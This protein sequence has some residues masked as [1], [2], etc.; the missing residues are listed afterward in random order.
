MPQK[1]ALA[2]NPNSGKTTLFNQLTGSTAHVGN[3]P[4]V[5]VERKEGTYKKAG[6]DLQIIDLPG[7]YSLSPYSPEEVVARNYILTDHPDAIINI[8]DGTNLERNLYLTTQIL[9][10]G[11]PVVIALNM[12][13]AVNKLG[14]KID[15]SALESKLGVPVVPISANRNDG[16]EALMKRVASLKS[17]KET[18]KSVLQDTNLG[19]SIDKARE[20]LEQAGVSNPLFFAVKAIENDDDALSLL[21]LSPSVT[22]ELKEARKAAQEVCEDG[23]VEATTADLRYKFITS[24]CAKIIKKAPR[25]GLMSTS[26]KIDRVITNKYLGIPIF[27]LI[28]FLVFHLTFTENLFFVTELPGPGIWLAGWVETGVEVGTEAINGALESMGA[29]DW[30]IGLVVDGILAGVGAVLGFLPLVMVLYLFLSLLESSGYMAR[31]AFIMDRVL[32][33]F[34]LSGKAFVPMLMGFGCSVPAISATRTLESD[35]DRKMTIMLI[36]FMSCGAKLPIYALIAPAV[37]PN[38]SDVAVFSMY[39]LGII[40]AIIA[41]IILKKKVFGGDVA[42][43]IMEL[44]AYRLPTLKSIG[45]HLWEKFKGFATKVGTIITVATIIIWFL[46]NFGFDGGF[47]MVEPNSAQSILG[48]VGNALRFIFIPLGF[49]SGPEGWKMVVAVIT[50]LV[51][52]EAVVSTMGQL[53]IPGSEDVMESDTAANN[54]TALLA[55]TMSIPAA[56][57]FMAW[58]LLSIPCMAAVGAISDEM[59]SRKWMWITLGF[60]MITAWI[61]SFVLYWASTGIIALFGL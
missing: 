59:K 38:R 10:T 20:S 48:Y 34:G 29:S 40:V 49:A 42:P 35:R 26:D 5:T 43:F 17:K 36:P 33:R 13:D 41:G 51:A 32:R 2:G 19:S 45:V 16:I 14:D 8:V 30:A 50:G 23:D 58:N 7:I 39:F 12:M 57:S 44:P 54:L 1:I 56:I 37:F 28:M 46:A 22:S 61:V 15:V 60:Q 55:S 4:G 31:A 11:V 3:W 25:K 18:G 47:G 53:Y 52:K 9:E 27:A 6:T 24:I 21:K